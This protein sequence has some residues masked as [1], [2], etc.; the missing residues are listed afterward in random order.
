MICQDI[1][2]CYYTMIHP[3]K[4]DGV[5]KIV[6]LIICR[7]ID[8]RHNIF[9][10]NPGCL[11]GEEKLTKTFPWEYVDMHK[12]MSRI[13]TR[14]KRLDT[15]IPSFLA[16]DE[17]QRR[18]ERNA[19]VEGYMQLKLSMTSIPLIGDT[20]ATN[21]MEKDGAE[22]ELGPEGKEQS[23]FD[24]SFRESNVRRE[25]S[26][27]VIQKHVR[28][29]LDRCVIQRNIEKEH[30]L[31]GMST[32]DDTVNDV[33]NKRVEDMCLKRKHSQMEIDEEYRD[34][35]THLRELVKKEQE[36]DM[37][38]S[39]MKERV[40]WITE[41][42]AKTNNIP[43]NLDEFYKSKNDMDHNL[44]T[45]QNTESNIEH[46]SVPEKLLRSIQSCLLR[47]KET[48]KD[49]NICASSKYDEHI[50]KDLVVKED[51]Y[52]EARKSVDKMLLTNLSRLKAL[53]STSNGKA[54]G[55]KG[56]DKK[57]K[58][59]SSKG[60]GKKGKGKALPGDKI[61][62]LKAMDTAHMLSILIEN[63]LVNQVENLRI[64]D[65]IGSDLP[66]NDEMKESGG[67]S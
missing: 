3:Q 5:K 4:R 29:H 2:D 31:L 23:V 41:Q 18:K 33:L 64:E 8:L 24:A 56:G 16:E 28:G 61:P 67:V 25:K 1:E 55:K 19:L 50:A 43:E 51:V 32:L 47:Y 53:Q 26:A 36:F 30:I 35:L 59:K 62:S 6:V 48:W 66:S 10:W 57:K 22:I 45:S 40:E 52:N 44:I 27:V 14:P 49:K 46:I 17:L 37:R 11:N 34:V 38:Q 9:K 13:K 7:I 39:L 12:Y 20:A 63:K 21:I 58:G 65:L 42:I 60:K 15:P 54:G